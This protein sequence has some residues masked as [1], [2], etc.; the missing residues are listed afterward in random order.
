M[1]VSLRSACADSLSSRSSLGYLQ[2]SL[3]CSISVPRTRLGF[4]HPPR[5]LQ[6]P[7]LPATASVPCSRF[8]FSTQL[9][10]QLPAAFSISIN[11]V[12]LLCSCLKLP[13]G[14]QT[15]T[16]GHR[17]NTAQALPKRRREAC[18]KPAKAPVEKTADLIHIKALQYRKKCSIIIRITIDI[19]IGRKTYEYIICIFRKLQQARA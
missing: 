3:F 10:Q 12:R 4:A 5:L 18:F 9:P 14:R 8:L 7:K 6:Q 11:T 17:T 15:A 16:E 19:T 1:N 2:Q 13:H